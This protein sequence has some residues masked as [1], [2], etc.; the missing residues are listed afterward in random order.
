VNLPDQV[1]RAV[2]WHRGELPRTESPAYY[3]V[4]MR[5][6]PPVGHFHTY[7]GLFPQKNTYV[8]IKFGYRPRRDV[9]LTE[10]RGIVEAGVV[11]LANV[12]AERE[13]IE[14]ARLRRGSLGFMFAA[15]AASD[16]DLPVGLYMIGDNSRGERVVMFRVV[17]GASLNLVI[18][19][20]KKS[21]AD[22]TFN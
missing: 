13:A 9:T 7:A 4:H 19:G 2:Q 3:E 15:Q 11:S 14:R 5:G 1:R 22:I 21:A 16:L 20:F 6:T 8:A 12:R 17:L 10:M 18:E